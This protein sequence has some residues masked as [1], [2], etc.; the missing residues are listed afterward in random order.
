MWIYLPSTSSPSAQ[1]AEVSISPLS[2]QFQALARS[3]WWRGKPSPSTDWL[4]RSAKASWLRRLSGRMP[5]PSTADRGAAL[6]MASLAASRASRTARPERSSGETTPGTCGDLSAAPLSS[7]EPGSAGSRTSRGCF[8]PEGPSESGMT[9]TAWASRLKADCSRRK[10]LATA[11]RD[12]GPSSSEWPTWAAPKASLA[13][14]DF[15]K[16]T[17]SATG[18][19]L[20]AQAVI[21]SA[22]WKKLWAAPTV[23]ISTGGQLTRGGSRNGELLL[24]GQAVSLFFHLRQEM[25]KDGGNFSGSGLNLNPLFVAALMGWPTGLISCDCSETG[26][27]LWKA[28]MR[29]ALSRL[30]SPDVA[31]PPRSLFG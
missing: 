10:K 4:K 24:A 13:G 27:F 7:L 30:G 5:E 8:R 26:L 3:A 28:R 11:K 20:P 1:E 14:A 25:L 16:L 12:A 17:R 18:L 31:G 22:V 21:W 15:A 29:F 9:Y 2:W 19:A 23:A 6:W